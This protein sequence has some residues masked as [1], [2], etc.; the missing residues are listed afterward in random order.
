MVFDGLGLDD[1]MLAKVQA[2]HDADVK[3]LK[4]KNSDLIE[5]NKTIKADSEKT[6]LES[7][8]AVEDAKLLLSEKEG[9]IASFKAQQEASKTAIETIKQEFADK[10]KARAEADQALKLDMS[11][12]EFVLG[13]SV[14]DIGSNLALEKAYRDS[15]QVIDGEIVPVDAT[16]NMK[17]ITQAIVQDDAYAK[18]VK[19]DVG[20]G[21]SA[22]GS[23]STSGQAKPLS[24]MTATE[25]AMFANSNPEQYAQLTKQ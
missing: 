18:Y 10:E 21:A 20:S 2:A 4:A 12:K 5:Q 19:A 23:T 17:E 7:A 13:T 3:G 1:E 22:A 14:G 6:A 15:I 11:V 9:D 8:Q 24:Q 25:E 16:K